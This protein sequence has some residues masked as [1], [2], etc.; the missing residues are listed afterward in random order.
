MALNTTYAPVREE[1]NGVKNTFLFD[2]EVSAPGDVVVRKIVRAT[3]TASDPLVYGIDYILAIDSVTRKG[4]V[5]Y[6]VAPTALEDSW[7]GRST[8]ATQPTNIP[9]NGVFR[10]VSIENAL[11]R[12]AMVSQQLEESLG[13]CLRVGDTEEDPP[14]IDDVLADIDTAADAVEADRVLAET[15]RTEAQNYA[16]ALRATSTS[17]IAIGTGAKTFTTQSGKQFAAGMFIQVFDA[18]NS[19]NFMFGQV[20][21]YTGT[22]LIIDSQVIGGTGTIASWNIYVSGARGATGAP[23]PAGSGSGDVL[24]PATNSDLY[25]PQWDGANTKTLKNGYPLG[26]GANNIPVTDGSSK[27]AAAIIPAIDLTSMVSGVLPSA[28][29]GIDSTEWTDY[30]GVST[31]FGWSS[32]SYKVI[33]YKKIGRLVFVVFHLNGVSNS[34][35]KRFSLPASLNAGGSSDYTCLTYAYSSVSGFKD[36]AR[37]YIEGNVLYL[38]PAQIGG[39]WDTSGNV[40]LR[41]SFF[42]EANS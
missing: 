1:G 17:S 27:L 31:I 16:L 30:S 42:Y 21:S 20:T 22:E 9:T 8:S 34:T 6:M 5:I 40:A 10:E 19:A 14:S 38:Y 3:N 32:F 29:G 2:F 24:G 15:A 18:A 28:N 39:D 41:G 37:G 35:V 7:I 36:A 12:Q 13:K 33:R 25:I 26:T 4:G 11:D 23:G